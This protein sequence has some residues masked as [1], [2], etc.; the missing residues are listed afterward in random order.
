VTQVM[1]RVRETFQ[2][3]MT[4]RQFFDAP[5]ISSLAAAIEEAIVEQV[6]QMSDEQI[7]RMNGGDE[8]MSSSFLAENT[9]P[10][11]NL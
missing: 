2:I 9:E 1:S 4:M 11:M 6:S 8:R 10:R 3:E 7:N 5:T